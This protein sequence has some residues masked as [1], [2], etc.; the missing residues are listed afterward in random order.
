MSADAI[1]NY[2]QQ[3]SVD[4]RSARSRR[5]GRGLR[6]TPVR[7]QASN[8]SGGATSPRIRPFPPLKKGVRGISSL[9]AACHRFS[10]FFLFETTSV[11]GKNLPLHTSEHR[12]NGYRV[13]LT[14]YFPWSAVAQ[15]HALFAL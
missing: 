14:L 7:G 13:A 9:R 6:L 15:G 3:A 11:L 4:R 5:L 12:N 1:L 8:I 10:A 2:C